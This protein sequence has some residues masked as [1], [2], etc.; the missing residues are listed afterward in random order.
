VLSMAFNFV[1]RRAA[2]NLM[3]SSMAMVIWQASMSHAIRI[4][5]RCRPTPSS[6]SRLIMF[7][8]LWLKSGKAP[9][10][11]ETGRS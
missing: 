2:L 3:S 11:P 8:A 4:A 1:D 5:N 9:D 7:M 6:L 10:V